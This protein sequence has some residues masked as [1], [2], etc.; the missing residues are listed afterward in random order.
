MSWT[1]IMATPKEDINNKIDW[2]NRNKDND[3]GYVW[4]PDKS[5]EKKAFWEEQEIGFDKFLKDG[6]KKKAR[7]ERRLD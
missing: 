7:L 6:S 2:Y 5:L 4:L 1:A 3:N